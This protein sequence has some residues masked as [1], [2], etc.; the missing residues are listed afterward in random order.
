MA[1]KTTKRS[2]VSSI[3]SISKIQPM[4]LCNLKISNLR[5]ALLYWERSRLY[6]T[7]Q[8]FLGSSL[9]P[10]QIY[11]PHHPSIVPHVQSPAKQALIVV[12]PDWHGSS[13][14]KAQCALGIVVVK[15]PAY[16]HACRSLGRQNFKAQHCAAWLA[17]ISVWLVRHKTTLLYKDFA[18]QTD[19]PFADVEGTVACLT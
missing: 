18:S 4:P 10:Q 14:F 19:Q 1:V 9:T 12:V 5:I 17:Y 13:K 15:K 2:S 3:P 16:T 7:G 6:S 11:I 8:L